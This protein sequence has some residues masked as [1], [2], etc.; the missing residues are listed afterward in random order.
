M[1]MQKPFKIVGIGEILWDLLPSGKKLGG[2]PANF[3]FHAQQLGAESVV[4]SSVGNDGLGK[5][6]I[7]R[8]TI[9]NLCTDF[10][11]IN[12]AYSTGIV[13]VKLSDGI[14]EYTIKSGVA[15][16]SI[17]WKDSLASLTQKADAVC[18]GTLAQR[19]EASQKTIRQF[20]KQTRPSCLRIFDI[21]L[22]QNFYSKGIIEESLRLA[23]VL[24]LNDEELPIVAEIFSIEGSE[25]IVLET[26]INRFQLDLVALTKGGR[27]S[28][29]KTKD[30]ESFLEVPKVEVKDTVGA[31]D[32]FTAAMAVALLS[33][34]EFHEIHRQANQVAAYVCSQHGAT[35][36]LPDLF[37]EEK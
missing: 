37:L 30:E 13:N 19:S 9:L 2:A 35:P 32:A 11:Q 6:I 25:K 16:D 14:P 4:V 12:N 23:S 10:I 33:G 36:P 31:G 24:K 20:V 8:L 3:A 29:L 18:F 17:E 7:D 15:W 1:A 21:N 22:R 26:L 5:E 28:L 34:T 27:G